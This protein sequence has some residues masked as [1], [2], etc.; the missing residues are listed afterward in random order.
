MIRI[1]FKTIWNQRSKNILIFIELFLIFLVLSN[2]SIYF[3]DFISIKLIPNCSHTDNVVKINVVSQGDLEE[4]NHKGERLINLKTSLK[5]NEYVENVSISTRA[6]PFNYNLSTAGYQYGDEEFNI[7]TRNVDIEYGDVMKIKMLKGRWFDESDRG[8]KVESAII[9]IDTE[10]EMFGGDGMG[11]RFGEDEYEVTGVVNAFKRS[12]IEKPFISM[13][14]LWEL[15]KDKSYYS[16]TYMVR[17]I[18][19]HVNDFLNIA[20]REV[21]SVLSTSDW[22]IAGLNTLENQKDELNRDIRMKRLI[23]ILIVIFV[24][25]NII[26][27]VVGIL[28]YNTNLRIHEIGIKRAIGSYKG[29][30]RREIIFENLV[31]AIISS[32]PVFIIL[33]QSEGLRIKPLSGDLFMLSQLIAFVILLLLVILCSWVPV[34]IA[35]SIHPANALKYE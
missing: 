27:G 17:I 4:G 35:S 20:S 26:L 5:S 2:L 11:K 24:M 30:I 29:K 13:F 21:F 25:I 34:K 8:K 6:T 1:F 22:T 18:P 12:D 16:V 33:A 23:G 32:L 7:A 19:G 10:K 15:E 28:W 31:L 3:T 9:G 14:R